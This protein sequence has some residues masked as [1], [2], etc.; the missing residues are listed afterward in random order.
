M[1]KS[2]RK[3]PTQKDASEQQIVPNG[4][5]LSPTYFW[6]NHHIAN[7]VA[8]QVTSKMAQ[9]PFHGESLASGPMEENI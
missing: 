9:V 5:I 6:S 4:Q 2:L 1:K 8:N 3:I 7:H